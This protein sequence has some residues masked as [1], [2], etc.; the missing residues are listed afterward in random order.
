MINFCRYFPSLGWLGWQ[1]H[2]PLINVQSLGSINLTFLIY[3][4]KSCVFY[5]ASLQNCFRS[6]Q[7]VGSVLLLSMY[8]WFKYLY[9]SNVSSGPLT[10]AFFTVL[11]FLDNS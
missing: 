10:F 4:Y 9:R 3:F 2:A 11:N 7:S 6:L 8:A 1:S 5:K